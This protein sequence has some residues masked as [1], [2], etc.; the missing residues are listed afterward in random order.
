MSA[1]PDSWVAYHGIQ[2]SDAP[3]KIYRLRTL[4]SGKNLQRILDL[5]T[6]TRR[7]EHLEQPEFLNHVIDDI[8]NRSV[9]SEEYRPLEPIVY[10]GYT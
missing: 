5:S 9:F 1:D 8:F 4:V 3:S 7:R 10:L 2:C 6:S